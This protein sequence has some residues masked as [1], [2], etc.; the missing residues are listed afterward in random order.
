[1]LV[2]ENV[3]LKE[4]T[5]FKIG[6]PARYFA[7]IKN[8]EDLKQAVDF[9]VQNQLPVFV[10]GG[11]SNL[12][13]SDEGVNGLVLKMEIKGIESV[14]NSSSL[15]ADFGRNF[16]QASLVENSAQNPRGNPASSV[17]QVIAGAG[18]IWD[19]LVEKCVEKE[20]YGLENLSYIPGTVGASAVQNIG[21]YGVEVK[22]VIGWVEVF[23]MKTGE[24]KKL[25]NKECLFGYRD[26]VFKKEAGKNFV[27]IRVAYNLQKN[28]ELKTDYKDIQ[29]SLRERFEADFS[30]AQLV[31][32]LKN[33]PQNT[34]SNPG[35]LNIKELR[36]IIIKIRQNKLPDWKK[37][38]TVGSFF[39]NI[40]VSKQ[41]L[42]KI[43]EKYP[44]TPNFDNGDGLYKIPLAYVLDKILGL[45]GLREGR[46]GLYE[47]QPLALVNY[48]DATS[49]EL[50]NLAQKIQKDVKEKFGVDIDFEA[51]EW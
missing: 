10:L 16:Q 5:T 36:D 44:E 32:P 12:L 30:T 40:V 18:E 2:Q 1:M 39:K 33:P 13:V 8:I 23:D 31:E 28:G 4:Y 25:E 6:G 29:M 43:L 50:K 19:E 49:Q 9:A 41:Q 37:V 20:L 27:V 7:V 21:A 42:E 14:D 34:R 47:K 38:G 3:W 46:V 15:R 45:K 48:S 17:V 11:G 26:S 51:V 22:D 35:K 24:I